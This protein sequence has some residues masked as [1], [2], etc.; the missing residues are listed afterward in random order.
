MGEKN[1]TEFKRACKALL[2]SRD[3]SM[4]RAYGRFLQL[5][6]PTKLRKDLL[7]KEIIE[8]L[9]GEMKPQRNKKGKPPKNS[10]IDP[11]LIEEI[12]GLKKEY[13]LEDVETVS[14]T[15]KGATLLTETL[16]QLSINPSALSEKQKQLLNDFLNSL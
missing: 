11:S 13:L 1:I 14:K 2:S 15:E 5:Q 8:V 9:C 10:Y 7:I 16:L 6:Y 4:L 12:N 3:I